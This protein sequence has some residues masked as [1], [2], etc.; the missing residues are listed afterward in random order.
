MNHTTVIAHGAPNSFMRRVQED[1]HIALNLLRACER[2]LVGGECSCESRADI[3]GMEQCEIC[4]GRNVVAM[5]RGD[6]K[7]TDRADHP[8][9][10]HSDH[11]HG[12]PDPQWIAPN[13]SCALC[14]RRWAESERAVR[15]YAEFAR[16]AVLASLAELANHPIETACPRCEGTGEYNLNPCSLCNGTGLMSEAVKGTIAAKG[17]MT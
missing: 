14:A 13:G 9:S 16:D 5:A 8:M 15:E 1:P 11:P 17:P 4:Y 2:L 3:L 10:E 12:P 7:S 6:E